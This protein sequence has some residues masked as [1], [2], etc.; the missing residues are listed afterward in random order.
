MIVRQRNIEEFGPRILSISQVQVV[1]AGDP[2]APGVHRDADVLTASST[3][4]HY[5]Y[6][7][8]VANTDSS[9]VVIEPEGSVDVSDWPVVKRLSPQD[10]EIKI[11]NGRAKTC[12][13][14][15][16]MDDM[17]ASSSS[18]W[19]GTLVPGSYAEYSANVVFDLFDNIMPDSLNLF[20][21]N[22]DRR[23]KGQINYNGLR[24][25]IW[26]LP[27]F[28]VGPTDDPS[29]D[30]GGRF[31]AITPR[32]VTAN[33][34]GHYGTNPAQAI[35][36]VFEWKDEDGNIEA[37][38]VVGFVNFYPTL[39]YAVYILDSDLPAS[40]VSPVVGD[41]FYNRSVA[42]GEVTHCI[43]SY[44]ILARNHGGQALPA[45]LI[46]AYDIV[47]D[48]DAPIVDEYG[49][50]LYEDDRVPGFQWSVA[51]FTNFNTEYNRHNPA[52]RFYSLFRGGDS[53]SP[54]FAP[55]A[56]GWAYDS[57]LIPSA[58]N[59]MIAAVD[60]ANG[61]ST[62]LTVTVAADPTI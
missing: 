24:A 17:M 22:S 27:A 10:V 1:T 21:E 43:Q 41:W 48:I 30:S 61:L 2:P 49:L 40:F 13:L 58:L 47:R 38:T 5:D 62:G 37:R 7:F 16:E 28:T 46:T 23:F 3:T 60:A 45:G 14:S 20:D 36:R 12:T 6:E 34:S 52:S 4:F 44:G 9:S 50:T 42:S 11:G 33:G 19:S 39:D 54:T 31:V 29:L 26:R 56:D 51:A 59:S 57:G 8:S 25:Q 18:E 35:G 32:H 53:A 15:L 55:V